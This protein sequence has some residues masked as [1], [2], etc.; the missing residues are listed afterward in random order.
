M[1]AYHE[2]NTATEGHHLPENP[3]VERA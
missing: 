3:Q 2:D 1:D